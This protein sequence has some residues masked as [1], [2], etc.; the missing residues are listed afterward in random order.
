MIVICTALCGMTV[1]SVAQEPSP[2]LEL[3]EYRIVGRD[4]RVFQIMGDRLSTVGYVSDPLDLP[5]EERSIETSQGLIGNDERL[6]RIEP[7]EVVYGP[8]MRGKILSGSNTAADLWGKLSLSGM[9][10]GGSMEI[11]SR[12]SEENTPANDAPSM[13]RLNAVGYFGGTGTRLSAGFGYT[14]ENDDLFGERFRSRFREAGRYIVDATLRTGLGEWETAGRIALDG[15]AF[16]DDELPYD[17]DE[18]NMAGKL[19]LRRDISDITVDSDTE[20]VQM[21]FADTDGYLVTTGVRGVML[22]WSDFSLRAGAKLAV[23]SVADEDTEF[24]VLPETGFD[25]ALTRSTYLKMSYAP[26]VV[27]FSHGEL[28][29]KNGLIA[30]E[31]MLVEYRKIAVDGEFGWRFGDGK[32][33]TLGMFHTTSENALVFDRTGDF[34][35]LANGGDV[36]MT[37]FTV[38]AVYDRGGWWGFDGGL[39][40]RDAS[41]DDPGEVPYVPSFETV[42]DGYLAPVGKW[43]VYGTLRV[44]GEH[45]ISAGSDDTEDGFFTVDVGVERELL[46]ILS[47]FV[48]VRNLTNSDGAWWT[49]QYEIPGTGLYGG[50]KTGF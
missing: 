33:L 48:E 46:D 10:P 30:P 27:S 3:D 49:S 7:S 23:S 9:G 14:G 29:N 13:Q 8:Y 28:Y 34:F 42:V 43:K 25:W 36:D 16:K 50:L 24:R 31:P 40:I 20:A 41:W 6:V 12:M 1:D 26:D 37:G 32:L 2:Q 44:L 35:T 19:S 22:L 45:Y 38:G 4:T 11:A 18:F 39:T 15:G 21:S 5:D 47:A 17:E